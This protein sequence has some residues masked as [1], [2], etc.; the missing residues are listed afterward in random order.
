M[1]VMKSIVHDEWDTLAV[2]DCRRRVGGKFDGLNA[3]SGEL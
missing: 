3:S 1:E 2:L